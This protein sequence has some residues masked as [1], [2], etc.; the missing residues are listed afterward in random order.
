[1]RLLKKIFTVVMI[2]S[3]FASNSVIVSANNSTLDVGAYVSKITG[4]SDYSQIYGAK[5][6][7]CY[8]KLTGFQFDGY[9]LN[10]YPSNPHAPTNF[11]VCLYS[12][13]PGNNPLLNQATSMSYIGSLNGGG[14]YPYLSGFGNVGSMY[15]LKV[16][17]GCDL[18]C[19]AT[20]YWFA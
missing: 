4:T 19:S 11:G 15:R 12:Y 1:M 6:T 16:Y 9:S 18:D 3:I 20:F 2:V 10:V 17:N 7:Y 8:I 13:N 5:H 14:S